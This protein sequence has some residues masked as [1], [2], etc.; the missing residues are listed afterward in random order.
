[1]CVSALWTTSPFLL[2]SP[3]HSQL[4]DLAST[5]KASV[6]IAGVLLAALLF[7]PARDLFFALWG[8]VQL[9]TPLWLLTEGH[10]SR[11]VTAQKGVSPVS[12][13]ETFVPSLL[14]THVV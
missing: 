2:V 5:H 1:M 11:A 9:L 8:P 14:L 10:G 7:L 12:A 6:V 3:L 4:G 13:L